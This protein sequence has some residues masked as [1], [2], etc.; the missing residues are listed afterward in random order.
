MGQEGQQVAVEDTAGVN[1]NAPE[2]VGK[3]HAEQDG[4]N[5]IGGKVHQIPE[6]APGRMGDLVSELV[7]NSSQ[8]QGK[9]QQKQRHVEGREHDGIG[10]GEGG[11]GD[12]AGSDEPHF[13]AIPEGT[14]GIVDDAALALVAGSKGQQG[15]QA[16]IKTVQDEVDCPEQGPENEPCPGECTPQ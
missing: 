10:L 8:D 5:K 2:Q 14:G 7:G 15:A 3:G 1:G 4:S 12:T 13:V 16:E 6:G 9:E 11:K